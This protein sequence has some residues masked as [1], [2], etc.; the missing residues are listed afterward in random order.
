MAA[1]VVAV[2]SG[3]DL[4]GILYAK[5]RV[6]SGIPTGVVF[7]DGSLGGILLGNPPYR[8]SAFRAALEILLASPRIRGVRLRVLR[9]SDELEA[10]R[11]MIGSRP[12]DTRYSRIR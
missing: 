12:L 3:R 1:R 10:V 2:Y 4:V 9:C 8:S 6:I 11:Q 5:E 7:A